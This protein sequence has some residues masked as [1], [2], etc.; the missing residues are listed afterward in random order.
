MRIAD[1]EKAEPTKKEI[2]EVNNELAELT[3]HMKLM[4]GGGSMSI[5]EYFDQALEVTHKVDEKQGAALII[6]CLDAITKGELNRVEIRAK[7]D[8]IEYCQNELYDVF[9]KLE[10]RYGKYIARGTAIL[11]R[12]LKMMLWMNPIAM[13]VS[14]NAMKKQIE[15]D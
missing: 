10:E 12:D 2:D 1:L 6:G 3:R 4:V 11:I 15:V 13:A 7:E 14:A 5:Q 9:A 8:S